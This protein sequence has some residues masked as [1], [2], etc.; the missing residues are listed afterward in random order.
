MNRFARVALFILVAAA[1]LDARVISYALYTDRGAIPAVQSRLN[2]HFVLVE[3]VGTLMPLPIGISPPPFGGYPPLKSFCTTP[4][5][6]TSRA[7][8][9]RRTEALRPSTAPSSAKM[10][11]KFRR[12]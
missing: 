9:F 10:N 2:R 3:Q 7:S 1:S 5:G 11:V 8:S 12:C 4:K 6:S